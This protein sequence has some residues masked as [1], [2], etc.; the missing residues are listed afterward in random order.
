MV[1]NSWGIHL[2]GGHIMATGSEFESVSGCSHCFWSVWRQHVTPEVHGHA[3]MLPSWLASERGKRT[4]WFQNLLQG[5]TPQ[6]PKDSRT[7]YLWMFSR[8]LKSTKMGMR[9]YH[10]DIQ[11]TIESW[12]VAIS[13]GRRQ[14]RW[15]GRVRRREW[16]WKH[17]MGWGIWWCCSDGRQ[18]KAYAPKNMNISLG[19]GSGKKKK[20]NLP[21]W[22]PREQSSL[23]PWI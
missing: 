20:E 23:I 16:S 14:G 11:D 1:T 3:T 6:R 4:P 18:K 22:G 13:W 9:F 19:A 8:P 5:Q 17:W 10:M 12:T 15:K 2:K 21:M 7:L